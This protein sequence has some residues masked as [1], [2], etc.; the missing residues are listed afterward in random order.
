M[1]IFVVV[2]IVREYKKE[3]GLLYLFR[4]NLI[5]SSEMPMDVSEV[6]PAQ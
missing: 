4:A 5:R 3:L 2:V 6:R 1:M